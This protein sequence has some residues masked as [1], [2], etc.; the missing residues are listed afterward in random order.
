[1]DENETSRRIL[2]ELLLAGNRDAATAHLDAWALQR[3][4]RNALTELVEPVLEIIGDQWSKDQL[5]LATGYIAGK[6][7]EDILLK[8]LHESRDSGE[9]QAVR[10][11][12][13]LGNIE[14]D[15]HALGRKMV[16]VF[17]R[18]AMWK[19]ID[20]GNDV[21]AVEFV[22]A[23]E[24]EG[25]DIIAVSAM[26]FTTA[27]NISEVRA[28]LDRRGLSGRVKLAVGGAVFRIRPELAKQLGADGTAPTAVEA[29]RL[30]ESLRQGKS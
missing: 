14:D 3:G 13:V 1:M 21:P 7:A 25:A 2:L 11:T 18:S 10:G 17:L 8:C 19:V 5:S 24:R 16:G 15:F 20:L 12:V 22:D 30:F 29:P 26:M 9:P 6:V 27:S 23:A 4:Y 28:E